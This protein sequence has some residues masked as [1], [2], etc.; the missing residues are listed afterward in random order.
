MEP[1]CCPP[2]PLGLPAVLQEKFPKSHII[3]PLLTKFAWSRHL[4]IGLILFF[5][6]FMDLD[7]ISVHQ[8]AKKELGQYSAIVTSHL[9]N[10]PYVWS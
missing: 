9:V 1:S 4:D 3:N 10:N 6:E 2:P 7:F 5:C 8:H